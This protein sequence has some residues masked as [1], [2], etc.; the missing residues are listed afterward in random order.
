MKLSRAD[1]INLNNILA[2]ANLG[3]IEAIVIDGNLASGMNGKN[4]MFISEVDVPKFG[5]KIGISRLNLLRQRLDLLVNDPSIVID[6]KESDRGEIIQ[7]EMAAG[8]NKIQFRCTSTA[9]IKAPKKLNDDPMGLI[10]INKDQLQM[11]LN[12]VKVMG[13][14]QLTINVKKDGKVVF[15][16]ADSNNDRM[17][18]ELDD[19]VERLDGLDEEDIEAIDHCYNT[20]ILTT[21]FRQSSTDDGVQF[22]VGMSGTISLLVNGHPM[23]IFS[24]VDE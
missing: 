11:I 10:K 21:L 20:D 3:G 16:T 23:Y 4:A 8:K 18:V 7:L 24:Q 2:T 17:T 6:A 15:I 14:K 9:L 12:S 22:T 19:V 13:A 1:A 5:Q